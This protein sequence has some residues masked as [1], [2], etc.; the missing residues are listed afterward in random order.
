MPWMREAQGST[1]ADI[2]YRCLTRQWGHNTSPAEIALE[3]LV[4]YYKD[5]ASPPP[6]SLS[7][8]FVIKNAFFFYQLHSDLYVI[9]FLSRSCLRW[10]AGKDARVANIMHKA[11]ESDIF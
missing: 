7:S 3:R 11:P 10:L 1:Y 2:R 8:V 4:V 5:Q 9:P 6:P